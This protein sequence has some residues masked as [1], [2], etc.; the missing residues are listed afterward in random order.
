MS[1]VASKVFW[2]IVAP[3][4]L[5]LTVL[6][7]GVLLF[8][9]G[10]RRFGGWLVGLATAALAATALLPVGTWVLAPL[11]DRFARPDPLP[12]HVD[13]IIVLGGA[14]E[15]DLA[16]ARDVPALNDAAERMIEFA[17]LAR[18]YPAAK[19]VFTG[20]SGD[21]LRQD[22]KEA[23][24]ARMVF[25][26]LGLET[27]TVLLEGSSRNTFENAVFSRDLAQPRPGET[28]LLVTS[29][30]HMPRSVG[31]FR[32]LGW[33]VVAYPTDYLTRPSVTLGL[34]PGL[35]EG[36]IQL[37]H[38]VREWIGL[39]AYRLMDRTDSLFPAPR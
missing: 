30:R 21:L 4:T 17:A 15:P 14:T 16:A 8:A 10:R 28:W 19:L 33:P 24:V 11:E 34:P 39:V 2:M 1:F 5:M 22:L 37:N 9:L 35:V 32:H 12:A 18:R 26:G 23:E 7:V 20:G 29:A 6:V 3:S 27:G 25:D 13:G 31:I 36:L 38:G